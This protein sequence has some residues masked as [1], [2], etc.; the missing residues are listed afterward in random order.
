M[1]T[2]TDDFDVCLVVG[3]HAAE[4]LEHICQFFEETSKMTAELCSRYSLTV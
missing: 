4:F 3:K 1:Y 2:A